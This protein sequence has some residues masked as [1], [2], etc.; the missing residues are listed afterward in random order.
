MGSAQVLFLGPLRSDALNS[1]CEAIGMMMAVDALKHLDG[2]AQI[3]AAV[4]KSTSCCIS[5]VAAVW[6][7][8]C[9]VTFSIEVSTSANCTTFRPRPGTRPRGRRHPAPLDEPHLT[10]RHTSFR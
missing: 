8:V 10:M 3:P 1:F 7:S 9:G 2:H 5:Q 4:R 6:R